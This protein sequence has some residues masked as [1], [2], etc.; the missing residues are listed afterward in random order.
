[1]TRLLAFL[2]FL[3]GFLST[4]S[5]G[6]S[7]AAFGELRGSFEPCG[8][9]PSTD[10]GGLKRVGAF[11]QD[12]RKKDKTTNIFLLGYVNDPKK[13][14]QNPNLKTLIQGMKSLK[15]S[16]GLPMTKAELEIFLEAKIPPVLTNSL[17]PEVLSSLKLKDTCVLGF[18][19]PNEGF[20]KPWSSTSIDITKLCGEASRKVLLASVSDQ[21]LET[22]SETIKPELILRS[23]DRDVSVKPDGAEANEPGKLV[24]FFSG[25]TSYRVPLGGSG[26]WVSSNLQRSYMDIKKLLSTGEL[27]GQSNPKIGSI[28]KLEGKLPIDLRTSPQTS[29]SSTSKPEIGSALGNLNSKSSENLPIVWLKSNFDKMLS[30]VDQTMKIYYQG[31]K[32]RFNDNVKNLMPFHA[33]S[34][35]KGSEACQRCHQSE[36]DVWKRTDHADAIHTLKAVKK[37]EHIS[38][39]GCHVV[40]YEKKGGYLNKK[41]TPH[42]AGVGCESCHGPGKEHMKNPSVNRL[43]GGKFVCTEC[44]VAPHSP[45]FEFDSYWEKIKHGKPKVSPPE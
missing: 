23:S 37:E 1:M 26:V 17:L 30:P 5:F 12:V 19:S 40:G 24:E 14:E 3:N 44:H 7:W 35:Y 18:V 20:A 10:L 42:L 32:Q 9:D 6:F 15:I 4:K 33:S 25:A 2:V 43:D 11:V 45:K 39:I 16:A 8:C 38:C 13:S 28:G 29:P 21:E 34:S 31:E 27:T 36:Y 22:L 41:H